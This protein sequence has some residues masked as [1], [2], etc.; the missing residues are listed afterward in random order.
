MA[1]KL[2]SLLFEH[3]RILFNWLRIFDVIEISQIYERNAD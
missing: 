2:D 3:F 1:A